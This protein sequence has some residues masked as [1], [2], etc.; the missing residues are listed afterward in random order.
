MDQ[1]SDDHEHN[2]FFKR[3]EDTAL[4]YKNPLLLDEKPEMRAASAHLLFQ[5]FPPIQ[6]L[7]IAK[8]DRLSAYGKDIITPAFDPIVYEVCE[9]ACYDPSELV[10]YEVCNFIRQQIVLHFQ[11]IVMLRMNSLKE[12]FPDRVFR[13]ADHKEVKNNKQMQRLLNALEILKS[14]PNPD[15]C[16]SALVFDEQITKYA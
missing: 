9:K 4:Q 2:D 1:S 15:I 10:R 12:Q 6:Y 8:P 11:S 5:L 13:L 7:P 16:Y 14:D 3:L